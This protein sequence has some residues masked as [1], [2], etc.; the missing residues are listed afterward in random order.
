MWE[1]HTQSICKLANSVSVQAC[2]AMRQGSGDFI[3]LSRLFLTNFKNLFE[4]H[5]SEPLQDFRKCPIR[6][7]SEFAHGFVRFH[8]L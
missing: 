2:V 3:K 7:H 1:S 8:F 5:K 6:T 4:I